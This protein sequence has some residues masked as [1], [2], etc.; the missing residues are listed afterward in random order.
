MESHASITG[1]IIDEP[2]PTPV[3]TTF[4]VD[5][6]EQ[7]IFSFVGDHQYR[8]IAGVNCNFR[9]IYKILY[10]KSTTTYLNASTLELTMFCYGELCEDMKKYF[11]MSTRKR[12]L[13]YYDDKKKCLA[14]SATHH[15]NVD[16]L[17]YLKSNGYTLEKIESAAALIKTVVK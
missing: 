17:Q 7:H 8:F 11:S 3:T 4:E 9:D 10:P 12:E 1:I 13:F 2:P 16:A 14:L 6:F 5:S 15:N